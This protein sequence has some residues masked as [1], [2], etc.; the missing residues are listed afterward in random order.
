MSH[1]HTQRDFWGHHRNSAVHVTADVVECR[2]WIHGEGRAGC[3]N[4]DNEDPSSAPNATQRSE[5][6]GLSLRT[7]PTCAT[8]YGCLDPMYLGILSNPD[9]GEPSP[10]AATMFLFSF[11]DKFRFSLTKP[12]PCLLR[13]TVSNYYPGSV[14][15]CGSQTLQPTTMADPAF[16]DTYKYVPSSWEHPWYLSG[17]HHDLPDW[18]GCRHGTLSGGTT[19]VHDA[20]HCMITGKPSYRR[21]TFRQQRHEDTDAPLR[22]PLAKQ[23]D[24]CEYYWPAYGIRAGGNVT[25]CPVD[26]HRGHSAAGSSPPVFRLRRDG[27]PSKYPWSVKTGQ[28]QRTCKSEGDDGSRHS[29]G[30]PWKRQAR[31]EEWRAGQLQVEAGAYQGQ[32]NVGVRFGTAEDGM[33][34]GNEILSTA[35]SLNQGKGLRGEEGKRDEGGD[36]GHGPKG[37]KVL[38]DGTRAEGSQEKALMGKEEGVREN[39][40]RKANELPCSPQKC[41]TWSKEEHAVFLGGLKMFGRRWK[42]IH[43]LLPGKSLMQVR[44]HA[45]KY[46]ARL[47]W[48]ADNNQ[49]SHEA[50]GDTHVDR[51]PSSVMTPPRSDLQD[52]ERSEPKR[53]TPPRRDR[54]KQTGPPAQAS[55][56][57]GGEVRK[58]ATSG[59]GVGSGN[60]LSAKLETPAK[61]ESLEGQARHLTDND[62]T[63]SASPSTTPKVVPTPRRPCPQWIAGGGVWADNIIT[64]WHMG[65]RLKRPGNSP[66]IVMRASPMNESPSISACVTPR[67]NLC[68]L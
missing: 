2:D 43:Q 47:I 24:Y 28:G 20:R 13:R 6:A 12:N 66:P 34:T 27:A 10:L 8:V 45:Y 62:T 67:S 29:F 49:A 19:D 18:V 14:Y 55:A 25:C 51:S 31:A 52:G 65:M 64:K 48:D 23:N 33:D 56:A 17:H 26:R 57:Q 58:G 35:E 5:Y 60:S 54:T 36:H 53:R 63:R 1:T 37:G 15:G 16:D 44:A 40:K 46:F 22:L 68:L 7:S 61:E 4:W 3:D 50:K 59:G 41:K 32:Q 42:L 11:H 30:R 21:H 38:P 9:H 39:K